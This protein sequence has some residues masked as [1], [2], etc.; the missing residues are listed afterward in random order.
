[1]PIR[2][3]KIQTQEQGNR[4]EWH[5]RYFDDFEPNRPSAQEGLQS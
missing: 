3:I 4:K 2:N 5:T 1:M